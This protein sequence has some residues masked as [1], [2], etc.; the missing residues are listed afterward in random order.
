[1]DLKEDTRVSKRVMTHEQYNF[2]SYVQNFL[3]QDV[4]SNYV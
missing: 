1:M 4:T 2:L 3:S